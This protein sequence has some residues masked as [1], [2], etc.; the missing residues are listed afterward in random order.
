M[1]PREERLCQIVF[2]LH[3]LLMAELPELPKFGTGKTIVIN[4]GALPSVSGINRRTG[5]IGFLTFYCFG[6]SGVIPRRPCAVWRLL[7][8]FAAHAFRSTG[9]CLIAVIC[10]LRNV[11]RSQPNCRFPFRMKRRGAQAPAS[12][13]DLLRPRIAANALTCAA[14]RGSRFGGY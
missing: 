4:G 7:V 5:R 3:Q 9:H 8:L 14:L 10:T 13:S 11:L 2:S 1:L 6:P 12:W